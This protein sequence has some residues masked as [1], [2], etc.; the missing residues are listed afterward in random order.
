MLIELEDFDENGRPLKSVAL[1]ATLK[2][3]F[4]FGAFSPLVASSQISFDVCVGA[5]SLAE[6]PG[7][8][9]RLEKGSLSGIANLRY[10]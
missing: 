9:C 5:D 2:C 6:V 3:P 7:A 4:S 8:S 1:S 10:P